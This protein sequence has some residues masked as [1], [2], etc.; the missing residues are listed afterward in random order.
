M[1]EL[2]KYPYASKKK[3]PLSK[4]FVHGARVAKEKMGLDIKPKMKG[5]KK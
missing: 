2:K 3:L 4:S 1:D 5:G